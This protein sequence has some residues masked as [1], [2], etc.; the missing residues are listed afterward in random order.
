MKMDGRYW[1]CGQVQREQAIKAVGEA[2]VEGMLASEAAAKSAEKWAAGAVWA[3]PLGAAAFVAG[4]GPAGVVAG[5]VAALASVAAMVAKKME[6]G[7]GLDRLEAAHAVV[8]QLREVESFP[9][10]FGVA[11]KSLGRA[12]EKLGMRK[13]L[14]PEAAAPE[15]AS[16]PNPR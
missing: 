3:I 2:A 5:V 4:A 8:G 1:V 12:L 6:V 11:D 7:A 9:K 10:R 16:A 13:R 15:K 14:G